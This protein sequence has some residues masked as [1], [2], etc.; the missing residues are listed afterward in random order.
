MS[1][2]IKNG[3]SLFG[4]YIAA[5]KESAD[6]VTKAT[7]GQKAA[8]RVAAFVGSWYFIIGQ[9]VFLALW[10]ALNVAMISL[11]WDPYP[12]ILMNLFLSTQAAYTAPMIL[13]SQNRQ[14]AQ[15]RSV[16]Y[17]GWNIDRKINSTITDMEFDIDSK[18]NQQNEKLDYIL[19]KLEAK[20][21]NGKK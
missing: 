13:M 2:D 9:S 17:S 4:H 6:N 19:A 10:I 12:F 15:D 18:L 16:L 3:Y 11:S 14:S 1:D 5:N 20:E 21:K 7:F 8:E